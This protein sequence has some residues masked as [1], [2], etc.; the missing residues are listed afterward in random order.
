MRWLM[1]ILIAICLL[2]AMVQGA[3]ANAPELPL[4]IR[5]EPGTVEPARIPA[6]PDAAIEALAVVPLLAQPFATS[7]MP[8]AGWRTVSYG[9][10]TRH[11]TIVEAV[12]YPDW[13]HSGGYAAW[14]NWDDSWD[15]IS[16]PPLQEEWLYSAPVNIPAGQADTTL[17]F[18]ALASTNYL[19]ATVTCY[20][21]DNA[22]LHKLWSLDNEQWGAFTY[23][24]VLV[25]L[26]A[27]QGKQI[28]IAWRYHGF[29]GDSF[30]L[31][32]VLIK[33]RTQAVF[34]PL[35]LHP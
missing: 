15:R 5:S 20:A 32:D 1:R 13:V 10:S 14:V 9:T 24:Q 23:R 17:S 34:I 25:S 26:G 29:D 35:T 22:G 18:W 12:H 19:T 7:A 8:P 30:G 2:M 16:P 31:D 27:Y 11:W 6:A 4:S 21:I 3:D 33:G 28:Q